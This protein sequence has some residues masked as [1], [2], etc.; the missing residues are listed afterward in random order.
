V[1]GTDYRLIGSDIRILNDKI[2]YDVPLRAKWI[3]TFTLR[4]A[5]IERKIPLSRMGC[6]TYAICEALRTKDVYW[7]DKLL[8]TGTDVNVTAHP[9][10]YEYETPLHLALDWHLNIVQ[11]IV[12]AGS[13][14]NGDVDLSA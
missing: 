6:F 3:R 13:P 9:N 8:K 2:L 10:K 7:S 11:R 4:G 1:Q 12:V 5:D 14:M